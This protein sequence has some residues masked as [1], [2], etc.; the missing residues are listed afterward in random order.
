MILTY[1]L[2]YPLRAMDDARGR[3]TKDA[4]YDGRWQ[5][6]PA[7]LSNCA[8]PIFLL[9]LHCAPSG[10]LW[11]FSPFFPSG[12]QNRAVL[13]FELLSLRRHGLSFSNTFLGFLIVGSL[14]CFHRVA[15]LISWLASISSRFSEG[16]F[17]RTSQASP[18]I[19]RWISRVQNNK[20]TL[21]IMMLCC[22]SANDK[23]SAS[24]FCY[25]LTRDRA[26][27]SILLCYQSAKD[28]TS[29]AMLVC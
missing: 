27:A 14:L 25:H 2:T 7:P 28:K 23:A 13:M 3:A 1:L 11:P 8:T 26:S 10:A 16:I 18:H 5:L 9:F 15:Y 20:V 19:F 21:L 6:I 4:N 22:Y 12:A 29:A 17:D 24:T